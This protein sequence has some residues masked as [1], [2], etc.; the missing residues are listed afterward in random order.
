MLWK[1]HKARPGDGERLRE[2]WQ[3]WL[4]LRYDA[5]MD[6]LDAGSM[7]SSYEFLE[8]VLWAEDRRTG[9]VAGILLAS[10]STSIMHELPDAAFEIGQLL[11]KLRAVAVAPDQRGQG[12]GTVLVR[13]AIAEYRGCDYA[14]MYGQFDAT[15]P[16]LADFYRRLGFT[17][18]PTGTDLTVPPRLNI[19]SAIQAQPDEHWFDLLL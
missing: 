1:L 16:R 17:I 18:H 11:V 3:P 9:T 2:L 12:L 4:G 6:A 5:A 14:W 8:L 10:P 15:E 7:F 19:P 13:R